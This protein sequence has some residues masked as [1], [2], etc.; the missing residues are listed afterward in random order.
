MGRLQDGDGAPP[1]TG[2]GA[3]T[4]AVFWVK[5]AR[6]WARLTYETPQGPIS[7]TAAKNYFSA[8]QIR[9]V[10]ASRTAVPG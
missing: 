8:G 10:V 9:T 1:E 2:G 4:G 5:P 7:V 3:A 6:E